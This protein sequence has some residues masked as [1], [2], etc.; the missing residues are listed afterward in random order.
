M[1]HHKST[2]TMKDVVQPALEDGDDVPFGA[3][4]A[5]GQ[6]REERLA[7]LVSSRL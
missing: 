3:I 4:E 5:L 6:G 7:M 1:G 2:L